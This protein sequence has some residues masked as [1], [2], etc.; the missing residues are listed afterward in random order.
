MSEPTYFETPARLRAW[1]KKH[2]ARAPELLM[3]FWKVGSGQP[4]VTW[5]Q[6]VDE[7]LCV[8]WI[9]GVR[10]RVDEA[11]Y[12][13]RFTPRRP[14]SIWSD[15]NVAKFERLRAA[16]RVTAA[17]ERAYAGR[18]AHRSGIYA[19]E[20]PATAE[21]SAD[22]VQAFRREAAAWA[23]FEAAP[24]GHR[25]VILHWV[26]TA[27]QPATRARRLAQLVAACAEG[28]RLR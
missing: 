23:Y 18:Q 4:S 20:Q 6:S 24:P 16:G 5:P 9:D 27:K 7:A 28:R 22:E 17:G 8:G 21:L 14:G 25:K 1:F 15:I 12:T 13:I 3:G 26:T 11:R 19:Y 10:K 2:H